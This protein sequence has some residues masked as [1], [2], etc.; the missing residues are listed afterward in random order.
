MINKSTLILLLTFVFAAGCNVSKETVPENDSFIDQQFNESTDD[1]GDVSSETAAQAANSYMFSQTGNLPAGCTFI[2]VDLDGR[3]KYSCAV[4]TLA[5]ADSITIDNLYP[6]TITLNGAL[7]TGVNTSINI[8]G[9]TSNL[10][11]EAIGVLNLGANTV[12]N[13][14]VSASAAVNVG[15]GS[16]I[17]GNIIPT[18]TAGVITLGANSKVGGHVETTGGAITIGADSKVGGFVKTQ[19]GVVTL[20]AR[21]EVKSIT[22][23]A[24][25]I[26]IG[27]N[28]RVCGDV[29]STGAGVITLTGVKVGGNVASVAG[30]ITAS[31]GSTVG[32]DINVTGAGVVTITATQV[33]GSIN[34]IAG[35]ITVTGST[36]GGSVQASG[37]GVVT[38]TGSIINDSSLVIADVCIADDTVDPPLVTALECGD[39]LTVDIVMTTD[40]DC[41]DYTGVALTLSGENISFNGN[42]NHLIAPDSP[43]AF[44][45]QGNG[46]TF[47]NLEITSHEQGTGVSAYDTHDLIV[48]NNT[49]HN[50]NIGIKV[51]SENNNLENL[52][53]AG[54][55]AKD[56]ALFGLYLNNSKIGN[57]VQNA[58]IENND[59]SGASSYAMHLSI[60]NHSFTQT[61]NNNISNS[62]NGLYLTEGNFNIDNWNMSGANI[63][64]TTIM[65]F[66]A[67]SIIVNNIQIDGNGG[68]PTQEEQGIHICLTGVLDVR[69]SSIR[70]VD[71]GIMIGVLNGV[72]TNFSAFD[73]VLTYNTLSGILIESIDGVT[74]FSLVE[75][76]NNDISGYYTGYGFWEKNPVFI[77]TRI[78]NNNSF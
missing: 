54:N 16:E 29:E 10:S 68:G 37:A 48:Q 2:S 40:L 33:Q 73:N 63:Q 23:A 62:M 53:V 28:S 7:T 13:A 24:G 5:A 45:I 43:V 64:K 58:T 59:F 17:T 70:G 39:V 32:S 50:S 71:V 3:E 26:T 9:D 77:T 31:A 11:I 1:A 56:S 66:A 14:N 55:Q 60:E 46:N 49:I 19:A 42:G 52:V 6:V 44:A 41:T 12:L 4:L 61:D 72:E 34:T 35:A 21:V 30:A 74:P 76:S 20:G 36:V 38:T 67:Q 75:L 27:A 65:G 8:D 15:I 18:G 51:Y 57:S 69:N 78:L 47:E 25:A 22:S